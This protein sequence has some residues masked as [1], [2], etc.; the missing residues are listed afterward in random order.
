MA[1]TSYRCLLAFVCLPLLAAPRSAHADPTEPLSLENFVRPSQECATCHLFVNPPALAGEPNISPQIWQGSLMGQSAR[2]PVFWAAVP[3]A[4]QDAPG[5]TVDCIRCHAPKAFLDGRGDAI[6]IDAL[7]PDDR[8]GVTCEIC[9][10]MVDDGVTAPGNARYVIDDMAIDGSV[11]ERGP[12]TYPP[13][14]QPQHATSDENAFTSS[15]QLCGVCHDV[16]TERE[17]VDENGVGLGIGFGEQRTYSEW[18]NSAFADLQSPHAQT[19]ADCHLPALD[20]VA[21]CDGFSLAG[22]THPDGGRR[23]D[24]AGANLAVL[25]LLQQVYGKSAGGMIEDAIFDHTRE[26]IEETLADAATLAVTFPSE[27]DLDTGLSLPVRVENRTG[28]KLPTGYA[29]GR[30]MWVEVTVQTGEQ[31][32]Y[33]SGRYDPEAAT[34]EADPQVRRYEAI[35]EDHTDGT[36]LHLLRSDRWVVDNRL[37]PRGLTPDIETDPVGD[38]YQLQDDNT[39]PHED[40]WTYMFDP[41]QVEDP[42]PGV[43]DTAQITVRL[44]YL[45]NTPEY[46]DLLVDDNVTNA[47]GTDVIGLFDDHGHP[48]PMLLAE[49]TA[50][51]P[52]FGLLEPDTTSTSETT[53]TPTDT[54]QTSTSAGPTSTHAATGDSDT[55]M[56]DGEGCGCR[57]GPQ[58]PLETITGLLLLSAA[59]RRRRNT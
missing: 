6:E 4:H 36:T 12:W 20:D 41:S 32:L 17:R 1:Q 5:E 2:D 14:N 57:T 53:D 55:G 30:V 40:S 49:Q 54:A 9:H 10:R 11:P 37:P 13:D 18:R 19:C 59:L 7:T 47:A 34:I 39:W 16:T 29:E 58:P 21:G 26:R 31:L 50:T 22:N 33:S 48:D 15:S 45:I 23:H 46:L 28:H 25:H 51:V 35:A 44:L 27:L 8:D 3:I 38:R 56:G 42:T 43:D 52:L 24:L